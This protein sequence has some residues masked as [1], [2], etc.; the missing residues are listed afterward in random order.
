MVR[1]R[2]ASALHSCLDFCHPQVKHE[3]GILSALW[4]HLSMSQAYFYTLCSEGGHVD[5]FSGPSASVESKKATYT[6]DMYGKT[7]CENCR[8]QMYVSFL[9]T[10]DMNR[11]DQVIYKLKSD[12]ES[13]YSLRT[14]GTNTIE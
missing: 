10:Y 13:N 8:G 5:I 7:S 4:K 11:H 1:L 12:L 9:K 14:L 3:I 2:S 6:T